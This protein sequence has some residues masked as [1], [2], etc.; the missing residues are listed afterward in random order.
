MGELAFPPFGFCNCKPESIAS[1]RCHVQMCCDPLKS[2]ICDELFYCCLPD[3]NVRLQIPSMEFKNTISCGSGP[4]MLHKRKRINSRI[5][6][7]SGLY[8]KIPVCGPNRAWIEQ[9]HVQN[10]F[11]SRSLPFWSSSY[12]IRVTKWNFDFEG[13]PFSR[14][15]PKVNHIIGSGTRRDEAANHAGIMQRWRRWP[16]S[17]RVCCVRGPTTLRTPRQRRKP[18]APPQATEPRSMTSG[19][20]TSPASNDPHRPGPPRRRH[21]RTRRRAPEILAN[22]RVTVKN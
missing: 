7:S 4:I 15:L 8:R 2:G 22:S 5:K 14:N 12:E 11:K 18:A 13:L 19:A 1:K 6:F 17:A 9:L 20:H 3:K 16:T 10:R 21:S